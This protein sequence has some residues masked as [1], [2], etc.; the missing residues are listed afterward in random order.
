ME[1]QEMPVWPKSDKN[2]VLLSGLRAGV[3]SQ[4]EGEWL[5]SSSGVFV[6]RTLN[7]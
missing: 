7:Q 4:V 2:E 1:T 3:V 5:L 6:S